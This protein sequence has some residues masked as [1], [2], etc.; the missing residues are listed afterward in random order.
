[1]TKN[2][3]TTKEV[4]LVAELMHLEENAC[5]KARLYSK[6]LTEPALSE[7]FKKIAESHQKKFNL[8]FEML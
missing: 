8:L 4:G 1:M 2:M 7:T 6:T 5:K 3:L